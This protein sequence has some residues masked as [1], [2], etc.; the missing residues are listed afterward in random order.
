MSKNMSKKTIGRPRE[1]GKPRAVG[2]PRSVRPPQAI[3]RR[4]EDPL[5]EVDYG[6]DPEV[7]AARQLTAVEAGFRRR[8]VE[9][10]K[11]MK[12]ATAVDY[13]RVIVFEDGEQSDARSEEHTSELQS[14]M[15]I[16]YAVFCL[17][18]KKSD[19]REKTQRSQPK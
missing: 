13:F 17:K 9:E 4:A 8:A 10:R 5:A 12:A 2:K 7:N 1:I 16:S 14:L 18:K 15:R 19:S 6:P 3:E 11:R